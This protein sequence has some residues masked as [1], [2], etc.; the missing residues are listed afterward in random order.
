MPN[1]VSFRPFI[2]H[3]DKS[4]VVHH[5]GLDLEETRRIVEMIEFFYIV[6][7]GFIQLE[8][9]QNLEPPDQN[10]FQY[11]H[12]ANFEQTYQGNSEI[13]DHMTHRPPSE[14]ILL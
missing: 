1:F 11:D 7:S 3:G 8:M 14:A 6:K 9:T 10:A 12:N 2:D 13:K 5:F 4:I